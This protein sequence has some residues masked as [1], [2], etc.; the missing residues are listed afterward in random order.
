MWVK[1]GDWNT[2]CLPFNATLTGDL[3]NA[4][5]ME[6]DTE[7]TYEGNKKTGLDDSDG[8]LYLYFK[9]ATTI[10]AGKPYI[11]RWEGTYM[12]DPI[13]DPTFTGITINKTMHNADFTGGSFRGNYDAR[14]FD[15]EN[16][17]ILLV[18]GNNLYW[19]LA[20]ASIKACRAY[21]E[22]TNGSAVREFK[23]NFGDDESAGITTTDFTDYT[24]K[25]GVWYMLDGRKLDGKPTRKGLYINNGVKVVIK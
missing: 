20:G 22:L 25:A 18:G 13:Q 1:D 19:P 2:L 12:G 15:A 9:T 10:E 4:T 23:L 6:L 11:I 3:A 21:F 16:K 14:T 7:G 5:L 24:D 17:S 8:T